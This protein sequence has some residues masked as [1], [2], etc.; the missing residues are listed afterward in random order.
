M[1]STPVVG[2]EI[3]ERKSKRVNKKKMDSIKKKM[4]SLASETGNAMARAERWDTEVNATNTEAD[5][6]EEVVRGLQKKIQATEGAYDACTEDVFN[7]TI[8]LEEMEK[9]ANNAEG[10]VGDLS[11]RV[12]LMEDNAV[13][14]EERL[15]SSITNLAKTSLLAD[16]C[17]KSENECMQSCNKQ[18]EDSE[19]LEQQLKEAQYQRTESENKYEAL[20][21]KLHTMEA[22]GCKSTERADGVDNNFI[23]IEVELKVVGQNQQSLEVSEEKSLER[24][25]KLQKQIREL[26]TKL[27]LA[28]TRSENSEMDIGRLN[29]RIDKVE[30]DLVIEKVKIK[31]VSDDLNKVFDDMTYI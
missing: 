21:R 22:E 11:R 24:E 2:T 10:Q 26:M 28:D 13:K 15:A 23:D 20:A 18:S 19:N 4:Q 8:K 7:Q 29:V 9:K 1:G 27:K 17:L 14:Y 25:E 6:K 30:E 5:Q 12:L 3:S 16:K 31:Q